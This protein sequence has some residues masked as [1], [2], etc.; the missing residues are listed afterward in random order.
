MNRIFWNFRENSDEKARICE[1]Y[2]LNSEHTERTQCFNAPKM[3]HELPQLVEEDNEAVWTV[4]YLEDIPDSGYSLKAAFMKRRSSWNFS[5]DVLSDQEI[6]T[7]IAYSFGIND[8]ETNLKTY[9]SGGR[10]YPIEIYIIPT[11]KIIGKT[12]IFKED[13][14]LKYNIHT[15]VLR[16]QRRMVADKVNTLISATDIGGFSFDQAQ[17]VVCLGGDPSLMKEKYHALTYRLMQNEC[18]HIGQ[19]MMLVA[20]M[21][22]LQVVPLGGF[23]EDRIRK[24][25]G[26]ESK[27]K[28]ILYVFAV[29]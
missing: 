16:L 27:T 17:F 22:N 2:H 20:P 13:Y 28:R 23:F 18:G 11:K 21:L 15:R 7:Y 14:S 5:N 3:D 9:P 26:I 1:F 19:N 12:K 4:P 6:E 29:G 24:L 10:L 25:L 8:K